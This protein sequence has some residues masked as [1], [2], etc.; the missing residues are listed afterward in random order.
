MIDIDALTKKAKA[1]EPKTL[2]DSYKVSG[3]RESSW[4][5]VTLNNDGTAHAVVVDRTIT[6]TYIDGTVATYTEQ[7]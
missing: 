4:D 3:A 7:S 2:Y 1:N 5:T 6:L